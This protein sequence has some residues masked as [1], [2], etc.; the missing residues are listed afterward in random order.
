MKV[1]RPLD[2]STSCEECARR[3]VEGAARGQLFGEDALLKRTLTTKPVLELR[4]ILELYL[5]VKHTE[6]QTQTASCLIK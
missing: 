1:D 4:E 6:L 5:Q 2:S 3:L